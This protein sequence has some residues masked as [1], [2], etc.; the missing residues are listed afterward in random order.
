MTIAA[1]R[2]FTHNE[3]GASGRCPT[4][5]R[6]YCRECLTE[7]EGRVLCTRCLHA[8]AKPEDVKS[9]DFLRGITR[10][11]AGLMGVAFAA[12]FF[13]LVGLLMARL[14]AS[15]HDGSALSGFFK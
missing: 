2:C 3:R 12:A 15:F 5:T 11:A 13:Y 8:L 7:H 14:P 10:G 4:C 1:Q 9:F 6:F